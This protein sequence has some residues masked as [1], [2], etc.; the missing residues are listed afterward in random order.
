MIPP[1]VEFSNTCKDNTLRHM[2]GELKTE[3]TQVKL[4]VVVSK[5]ALVFGPVMHLK[6]PN[7]KLKNFSWSRSEVREVIACSVGVVL[8]R[9]KQP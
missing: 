8:F 5:N 4:Y 3:N 6:Q 2:I 7:G 1:D 9:E